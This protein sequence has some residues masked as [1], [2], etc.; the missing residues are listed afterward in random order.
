M[1]LCCRGG[2][3]GR[4]NESYFRGS[5]LDTSFNR[6][7]IRSLPG[8]DGFTFIAQHRCFRHASRTTCGTLGSSGS[9]VIL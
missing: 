1:S 9:G 3:G 5:H 8:T 6:S 7:R 4:N 2:G